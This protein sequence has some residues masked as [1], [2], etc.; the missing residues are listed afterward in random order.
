MTTRYRAQKDAVLAPGLAGRNL[1]P[2][3]ETFDRSAF[4]QLLAQP[5]CTGVRLYYGMDET[6]QLHAVIVGINA[7]DED[8]LPT[9]TEP[10]AVTCSMH[11][12]LLYSLLVLLALS[13]GKK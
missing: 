2:I 13:V 6:L 10:D 3:S 11:W 5:G 12:P 1:L 7:K 4:D 8:I 9:P